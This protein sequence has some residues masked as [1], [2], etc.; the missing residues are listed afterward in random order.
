MSEAKKVEHKQEKFV[1]KQKEKGSSLTIRCDKHPVYTGRGPTKR[2]WCAACVTLR[3]IRLNDIDV[4]IVV[5]GDISD[6]ENLGAGRNL[7]T[8]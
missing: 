8:D 1:R 5:K 2:R 6:V 7:S 3:Y 4:D